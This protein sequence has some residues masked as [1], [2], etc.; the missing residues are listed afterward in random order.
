[1]RQLKEIKLQSAFVFQNS[2]IKIMMLK[3]ICILLLLNSGCYLSANI[4]LNDSSELRITYESQQ[5][6]MSDGQIINLTDTMVLSIDN[7]TSNYF[8]MYL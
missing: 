1:M 4:L 5:K 7:N 8:D 2:Q 6:V 3:I